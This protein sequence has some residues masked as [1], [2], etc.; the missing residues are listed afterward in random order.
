MAKDNNLVERQT[1]FS[2]FHLPKWFSFY[3]FGNPPP[4]PPL[5]LS[6]FLEGG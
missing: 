1:F 5:S 6:L 4:P 3:R 2:E